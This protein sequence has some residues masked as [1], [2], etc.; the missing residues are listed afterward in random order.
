MPNDINKYPKVKLTVPDPENPGKQR[1]AVLQEDGRTAK[2]SNGTKIQAVDDAG[3]FM[4]GA[5][6]PYDAYNTPT[7]VSQNIGTST[8]S[9]MS[10]ISI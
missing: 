7:D 3:E 4:N 6:F 2:I 10:A 8:G 5:E 9:D 1:V